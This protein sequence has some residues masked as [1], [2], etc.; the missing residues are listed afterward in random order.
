[1]DESKTEK[2]KELVTFGAEIAGAATGGTLGFLIAGPIGAV[3]GAVVGQ[4]FT[5]GLEIAA[6]FALRDLSR[7]E[8]IKAGAGLIFAY[9][10][11]NKYLEEGRTPRGDDFFERDVTGR[12][13]SD[14]ILEGTLLRC[15]N[16]HEEKKLKLIGNIFANVAFM[17]EVKVA[18][19]NWLLQKCQELTYRQ[20][21]V[22]ALIEQAKY[23]GASWGPKDG[24]PA[25][26]MEYKQIDHMLARDHSPDS[27]KSYNETGE[28]L[29]VV[30]LSRVGKFCHEVMGL[31]EIPREDLL[32]LRLHFPRAFE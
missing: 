19:A 15:K 7:R 21:C 8:K 28:G 22:I 12:S 4:V 16:E 2:T 1:M 17:P 23:K 26:E 24:D 27:T 31:K 5:K 10:K 3:G 18:G 32:K 11:I 30:G 9:Y 29:W 6:D 20:L 25:F 13:A 14:E